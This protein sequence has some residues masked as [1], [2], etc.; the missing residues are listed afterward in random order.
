MV[1]F[2]LGLPWKYTFHYRVQNFLTLGSILSHNYI[3]SRSRK[4]H[5]LIEK[6]IYFL[7][8]D[9]MPRIT[10]CASSSHV[11]YTTVLHYHVHPYLSSYHYH[12]SGKRKPARLSLPVIIHVNRF[13][14]LYSQQYSQ[15]YKMEVTRSLKNISYS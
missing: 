3:R 12:H 2:L 15:L 10:G 9:K 5:D 14:F 13:N 7:P 11:T 8:L 4:P 6:P 1:S